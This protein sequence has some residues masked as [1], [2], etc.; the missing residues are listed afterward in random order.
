MPS[1]EVSK[2]VGFRSVSI[3][4]KQFAAV[5]SGLSLAASSRCSAVDWY[6]CNESEMSKAS[7]LLPWYLYQVLLQ[8]GKTLN[9]FYYDSK[10]F[11]W[12]RSYFNWYLLLSV[13]LQVFLEPSFF[14]WDINSS[15]AGSNCSAEKHLPFHS[16]TEILEHSDFTTCITEVLPP[17]CSGTV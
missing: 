9:K 6:W 2:E 7:F 17:S 10:H 4:W 15:T 1:W 8:W 14:L 12:H 11:K 3:Q 13:L 5:P 16:L